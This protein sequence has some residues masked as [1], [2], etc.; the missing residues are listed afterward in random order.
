MDANKFCLGQETG[1]EVLSEQEKPSAALV[2]LQI[3]TDGLLC[4]RPPLRPGGTK[5]MGR[6]PAFI[7]LPSWLWCRPVQPHP[8]AGVGGQGS[9]HHAHTYLSPAQQ[10]LGVL[11]A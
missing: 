4:V 7:H 9:I 3:F 11:G 5:V 10:L 1:P 2:H 8:R 6:K